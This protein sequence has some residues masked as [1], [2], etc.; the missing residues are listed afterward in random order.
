MSWR[1]KL[2]TIRG[3][4]GLSVGLALLPM[5]L[6]WWFASGPIM[7]LLR[8]PSGWLIEAFQIGTGVTNTPNHDWW[9]ETA[10][11][12]ASGAQGGPV[13]IQ[14]PAP[15]LRRMMLSL[16]LFIALI[17]SKPRTRPFRHAVIGVAILAAVFCASACLAVLDSLAVIVN[18][19]SS[20]VGTEVAPP[21]FTVTR[22]HM[23]GAAFFLSG[24]G[25][26]LALQVLPMIAP[27]MVWAALNWAGV[28]TLLDAE[29]GPLE[30]PAGLWGLLGRLTTSTQRHRPK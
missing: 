8:V 11:Q 19:H 12:R 6:L 2:R 23:S 7:D 15:E 25:F 5:L 27:V 16:P 24:L 29:S 28:R 14:L 18:H 17:V 3:G 9:V 4:F 30:S 10:L 20:M 13:T 22:P 26:Y 1:A 21:N